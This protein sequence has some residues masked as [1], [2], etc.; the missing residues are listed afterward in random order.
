V[1]RDLLNRYNIPRRIAGDTSGPSTGWPRRGRGMETNVARTSSISQPISSS[2]ADLAITNGIARDFWE[3]ELELSIDGALRRLED[4]KELRTWIGSRTG[5]Q[6]D[7]LCRALDLTDATRI[8]D[9]RAALTRCDGRLTPFYLS[10]LF[11]R[12][13]GRFA[14]A[15]LAASLLPRDVVELCRGKDDETFDT[16]ALLYALLHANPEHF[17]TL[18]HLDKIH[19]SGFARMALKQKVRQP[20]TPFEKFLTRKQAEQILK[21][22]DRQKRDQRESQLKNIIRHHH[23]RLVFIRRPEREQYIMRE[24]RIHHGHRVE[25]IILDFADNVRRVN[26]SSDSNEVPLQI[27]NA[28]AS[29]YFG[30]D[31]EYDNEC[32]ITYEKQIHNLL[33]ALKA[34][35]CEG[36]KLVDLAPQ[37]SAVHGVNLGLDHDDPDV[38][39]RA[40]AA[41][42]RDYGSLTAHIDRIVKLKVGYFGTRI[43]VKFEKL[44]DGPD[45]Y[46]VRYMDHRLNASV[47]KRFEDFMRDTHGIPILSTEKRFARRP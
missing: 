37:C 24:G 5:R 45:E 18:F 35:T 29:A 39:Q 30:K 32:Q 3:N 28:L 33:D 8:K 38:M 34:G 20:D 25:W 47:R 16:K 44:D 9:K 7:V 43:D 6:L 27:A 4:P 36:L 41:L 26:I 17:K 12:R 11:A 13:K 40:I 14:V 23:H 42:E 15:D 1:A 2:P 46:I 31:V 21:H 10:D 22:F 19:K